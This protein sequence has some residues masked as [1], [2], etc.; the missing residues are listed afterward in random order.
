MNERPIFEAALDIDD[1]SERDAFVDRACG[2][3]TT[4]RS[5]LEKLLAAHQQPGD[6]MQRPAPERVTGLDSAALVEGPGTV[7]GAYKLLEQIGEGAFGFVY[8]AEQSRPVHRCIALKI[9]KPGMDTR[10]VVARFEAE[11]QAL[12]L[13]DHPNIAQVFDGG[14]TASGRPYFVMELVRGVPITQFCD[15]NHWPLRQ[16]LGLFIDVCQAVQHAHQKGIIHRDLKPNNVLITRHDD[17]AVVKV[18]DFGIAKATAQPLTEKTLFTHLAQMIGTPPYMSPEQAQIGPIDVDTRSD[19][20]SLGVLL[21]ELLT[22]TTPFDSE[23]LKT[24]AYD[25]VRRII[26][27]EE[28]PKPSTRMST[29]GLGQARYS[30]NR[31][32]QQE[33]GQRLPGELDWIVMKCLEKDRN[34]RYATANGLAADVERYLNDEPVQACPPSAWYRFKKVVR[35]NKVPF[36]A[37]SVVLVVM[38]LSIVGLVVSNIRVRQEQARTHEEKQRAEGAEMLAVRRA[39]EIAQ[40]MERLK[41]ANALVDMARFFTSERRWDDASLAFTSAIEARPDHAPA[42]DGRGHLYASLGLWDLA[43]SDLAR[44]ADL[45]EPVVGIN[46]LLLAATRA[47]VG[48]VAGYRAACIRMR[49]RLQGS[50]VNVFTVDLV[51]ANALTPESPADPADLVRMAEAVVP[52]NAHIAWFP[53]ALGAAH[54]RAGQYEDAIRRLH[55]SLDVDP[56]WNAS[57][58]NY[59]YLAMAYHRLGRYDESR[60]A[61]ANVESALERWTQ[62]RY[63]ATGPESWVVGQG[64]T[65]TSPVFWWDWLVCQ[66][67]C[68]EA[69]REMGMTPRPDDP[70]QHVLRARALAGLRRVQQ[71]L[72]EYEEAIR[73]RPNDNRILLEARRSRAFVLAAHGKWREAAAEYERASELQPDEPYFWWYQAVLY[74]AVSDKDSYRRVC[75]AM[76]DRFGASLDRRTAHTVVAACTLLPDSVSDMARLIPVG[77]VA[78]GWYPG[79]V[80]ML[81]AAQ[82]RAGAF[83]EAADSFQAGAMHY[84]LRANDWLLLSVTHHHLGDAVQ[85]RRSFQTALEWIDAA[86]RRELNDPAGTQPGWGDWLE[87][88]YVPLLRQEV[89]SLLQE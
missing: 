72:F 21:Y 10:Q 12:A 32:D 82:C 20:Y 77:Q 24:A 65:D 47:Y 31:S 30:A 16:R 13:M 7:I 55:E 11:R 2:T 27:E 23:R 28:P 66:I 57:A 85:A 64:A 38:L 19:I 48:D 34:R 9:L 83:A 63:D 46:W 51:R 78:A 35:R 25:E 76:L 42:W 59:P 40:G 89:E 86:D 62:A 67:I 56:N 74:L 8:M 15:D 60:R 80:R 69:R 68:D 43:A 39:D 70:R 52:G 58:V 29:P 18:I 53:H 17:K 88:L 6:F 37:T 14:E 81:A 22:G 54:Y 33:I 1:L 26:T 5:Q 75:A 73:Q 61:L 41:S 87:P 4:L 44:A 71:A 36:T 50:T 3:D 45:Q 84:R 79:G 49:D